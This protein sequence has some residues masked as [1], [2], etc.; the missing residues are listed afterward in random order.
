MRFSW[1]QIL[2]AASAVVLG[3]GG[4][5]RP[6]ADRQAASDEA[7]RTATPPPVVDVVRVRRRRIKREVTAPAR[8]V[9][10]PSAEV[11]PTLTARV[12]RVCVE[13]GDRVHRGQV[14][15]ELTAPEL[16]KQVRLCERT[17]ELARAE[18]RL[19]KAELSQAQT[20]LIAGRAEAGQG[21]LAL[22]QARR[23]S[24]AGVVGQQQ[25]LQTYHVS[26]VSQD[27][28]RR[29]EGT[30]RQA[31]ERVA[32]AESLIDVANAALAVA[33]AKQQQAWL[34]APVAGVVAACQTRPG[35]LAQAGRPLMTLADESTREVV[36]EGPEDRLTGINLGSPVTLQLGRTATAGRVSRVER[37]AGEFGS[38]LTA[39]VAVDSSAASQPIGSR[40]EGTVELHSQ[41]LPAVPKTAI[42]YD[43]SQPYAM[44]VSAGQPRRTP[45][46]L[47]VADDF[48]VGV[49]SGLTAGDRVVQQVDCG[50][51]DKP[52]RCR[53]VGVRSPS[54]F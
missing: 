32:V 53:L 49:A 23:Q 1:R 8:V 7:V 43:G 14:L 47:G 34:R 2:L 36:L 21:R 6:A 48:W 30:T 39:V 24:T 42:G 22:L 16:A 28:T 5:S 19:A 15:V 31:G 12:R 40:G 13:A 25:F 50:C 27:R 26:R 41:W 52:C 17:V 54:G 20:L 45:V 9:A 18:H 37:S 38:L 33:R 35:A 29:L 11:T 4:C 3:V 46:T 44:V 10:T 51:L